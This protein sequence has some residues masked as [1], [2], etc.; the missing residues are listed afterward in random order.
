MLLADRGYSRIHFI[1]PQKHITPDLVGESPASRAIVE[2][3]T[4]NRSDDD[5]KRNDPT[6]SAGKNQR[7]GDIK[8]LPAFAKK[9]IQKTDAVSTFLWER[10]D[11]PAQELL[12]RALNESSHTKQIECVLV[13]NLNEI[14]KGDC[15]YEKERF[16]GV[17][18]RRLTRGFL[19]V[20]PQGTDLIFLNRWLLED[21]Y[22][23][24]LSKLPDLVVDIRPDMPMPAEFKAKLENAIETART[25]LLK[26]GDPKDKRIVLLVINRDISCMA[27][28]LKEFEA[29]HQTSDLEVVCQ[30]GDI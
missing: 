18:L 7:P 11:K 27:V 26:Y 1:P 8:G 21:A 14:I 15:V 6:F 30:I 24:E 22:P 29:T 3:K 5:R 17:E 12:A 9:L 10:L 2:V 23:E 16:R 13:Q 19:K 28:G 4:I 25:Q 20:K